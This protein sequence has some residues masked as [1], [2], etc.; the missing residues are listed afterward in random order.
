MLMCNPNDHIHP[1]NLVYFDMGHLYM[2]PL[3]F[4]DLSF[5]KVQ[6]LFFF[7]EGNKFP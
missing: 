6:L 1:V 3:I 2:N 4:I 7:G 5:R